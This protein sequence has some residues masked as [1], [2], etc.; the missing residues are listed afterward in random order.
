MFY[1]F[2]MFVTTLMSVNAINQ[3][4]VVDLVNYYRHLN[5]APPVVYN[6][7]MDSQ[8]QIWAQHLAST[9]ILI[10]SVS[11]GLY[12]ENL[13]MISSGSGWE[14]IVK[15]WYDEINHYNFSNPG[16]SSATG[17]FTQLVWVGTNSISMATATTESGG[18]FVVMRFFPAGNILGLFQS[19]VLPLQIPPTQ[20]PIISKGTQYLCICDC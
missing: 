6:N 10:H 3:S 17:H 18:T 14:N 11:S 5:S 12:G 13:G 15:M 2:F 7:V 8:T 19:N 16:F 9:G 1:Y 20:H 4:G